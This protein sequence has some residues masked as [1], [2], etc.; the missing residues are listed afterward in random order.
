MP[1]CFR[2]A[3]LG[4]LAGLAALGLLSVPRDTTD[5]KPRGAVEAAEPEQAVKAPAPAV[6][7]LAPH[8]RL[9]E[10]IIPAAKS[11]LPVRPPFQPARYDLGLAALA[12]PPAKHEDSDP[13]DTRQTLE[14]LREAAAARQ[15]KLL[16]DWHELR[17]T[18]PQDTT[19][20]EG[21][22]WELLRYAFGSEGPESA[23]KAARRAGPAARLRWSRLL[24][25]ECRFEEAIAEL[26][27]LAG[28][29]DPADKSREIH[30]QALAILIAHQAERELLAKTSSLIPLKFDLLPLLDARAQDPTDGPLVS[31]LRKAA[32][33]LGEGNS[34]IVHEEPEIESVEVYEWGLVLQHGPD[35][36]HRLNGPHLVTLPPRQIHTARLVSN[37][38]E[39]VLYRR[40]S[41][42][43]A[44]PEATF[45]LHSIF[46]GP[47]QFRLY[48]FPSP[49]DIA[50]LTGAQLAGLSAEREWVAYH[51]GIKD[52]NVSPIDKEELEVKLKDLT[53]GH[54]FMTA[55]ARYSPLLASC[56]FS[57]SAVA[58]Y[59][60]VGRNQGA[61]VA[62]DRH[63]AAPRANLPLRLTIQGTPQLW[64]IRN[65]EQVEE[66]VAAAFD[67]GFYNV[68]RRANPADGQPVIDPAQIARAEKARA[69]GVECRSKYTQFK[70][71]REIAT[72]EQ[73]HV[74]FKLDLGRTTHTYRVD[75]EHM[76][77]AIGPLHE[78][79]TPVNDDVGLA[80]TSVFYYE[81]EVEM[82]TRAMVWTAQPIYRPGDTVEFRGIVRQFDGE[83]LTDG[84]GRLKEVAVTVRAPLR[85]VVWTGVCPVSEFGTIT[86]SFELASTARMGAY[87]IEVNGVPADS[88]REFLVSAFR[89]P[90]Y[91]VRIELDRA[92]P[93]P[94]GQL[95]GEVVVEYY[96]G[97]PASG[98]EVE[99]RSPKC[100]SLRPAL[101]RGQGFPEACRPCPRRSP[102]RRRC[103]DSR[104][105][106]AAADATP[107]STVCGHA[108]QRS[109]TCR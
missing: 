84:R 101:H 60:H 98:A 66:D 103:R 83:T 77:P 71:Q 23:L 109:A 25:A 85:E 106:T 65:A 26:A 76:P 47:I 100:Q 37:S 87:L 30:S 8:M 34:P 49:D 11:R 68:P 9:L 70:Q 39:M 17:N 58:L 2:Y 31:R 89:V 22:A 99:I 92:R 91:R 29:A 36:G 35:D 40:D 105:D 20:E 79:G 19:P 51:G 12:V 3:L 93:T 107:D 46:H 14:K 45:Q 33:R 5:S 27:M 15:M 78:D 38:S 44:G 18:Q 64:G 24:L 41:R 61:V 75:V 90:T 59:L 21:A 62:V 1:A 95:A 88:N 86:G 7:E 6:P 54:Y 53:A 28:A 97:K 48:R 104:S 4:S 69:H 16:A 10:E 42:P 13:A 63:T 57:V 80:R 50:S 32:A 102:A 108:R 67:E 43:I 96:A 74:S 94:G 56:Q 82:Q 72:D 73:G 55:Q 81:S 52:N